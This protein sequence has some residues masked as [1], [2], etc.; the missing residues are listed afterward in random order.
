VGEGR[1]AASD[2]NGHD[3]EVAAVDQP[4]LHRLGGEVGTAQGYS[5]IRAPS[6][7]GS[8]EVQARQALGVWDPV[9]LP[10]LAGDEA[11]AG[12]PDRHDRREFPAA[13]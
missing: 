1:L 13:P 12:Q 8:L 3:E 5:N 4:G 2:H 6:G 9:F 7:A 10:T 11:T